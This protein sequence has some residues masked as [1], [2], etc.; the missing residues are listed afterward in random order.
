ML[1]SELYR[2]LDIPSFTEHPDYFPGRGLE[3]R[4]NVTARMRGREDVD[5]LMLMAH[6]DTVEIG[7]PA[8]WSVDPFGGVMRDGKIYG[9]GATD[10]KY[11]IA[12]ALFIIKLLLEDGFVPSKN[13]LFSAYCD[14][15]YGGSHGALAAALKYPSERIISMDGHEGEIWN[16]A[17][18][19]GEIKYFFHVKDTVNTA[20]RAARALPIVMD[21]ISTFAQARYDELEANPYYTGTDVPSSS[22]R[23]MGLRAGDRGMNLDVGEAYFV[24]YTDKTRE[25]IWAELHALESVI[26]ERLLPLG[27][28][29]DGFRAATRFFHYAACTRDCDTV[30]TLLSAAEDVGAKPL[31]VIGSCLSDLSII[32]KYGSPTAVGFG[33]GRPFAMVGGAH[34][35]DEFIECDTL[36]EYTKTLAAYILK[37]LG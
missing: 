36:V 33:A 13:L 21:A 12:A 28:I 32:A 16:A 10:D 31:S 23:Y 26:A 34:Q 19:G 30:T 11:A 24:F 18:G 4:Y 35:P 29:G 17:S 20:E 7:D 9:R 25:E 14:E 37:M 3:D 15:E 5:S 27:I 2:P 8:S 6:T 22:L 1:E